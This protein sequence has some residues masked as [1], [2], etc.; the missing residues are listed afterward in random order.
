M[1]ITV[2]GTG[3][4]GLVTGVC[5]S[6]VGNKVICLDIDSDKVKM[7]KNG[8]SPIYEP[9]LSSKIKAGIEFQNLFFTSNSKKAIASS[10]VIFIAVGTPSLDNG[11]TDLSY[12][13][14]AGDSIAEN[15]NNDKIIV[16][17]STVPVGTTHLLKGMVDKYLN[18]NNLTYKVDFISNPE[19]LKE[20]KAIKDF[21]SP[22]RIVLG[23]E[24]EEALKTMKELY[25]PFN[26]H[27]DKIIAMDIKSAELTKYAANAML[28]TKIS[29]INEMANI[30]EK[31][32]ADINNVRNGIGSDSRIG[33][34]FIY[35]GIGFG[36]SCFP[37]D[38]KSI[39]NFSKDVGYNPEIINSVIKV[40]QKQRM[41]F[42]DRIVKFLKSNVDSEKI[43]VG[44]WGLSF[45]PQ[46]DDIREAPSL[47]VIQTL[48]DNDIQVA[49]YDPIAI[50]NVK[51]ELKHKELSFE[52]EMYEVLRSSNALILCTEW[53]DFRSPDFKKMGRLMKN[54]VIFDG[55]NIYNTKVLD[56]FNFKHFQIGVKK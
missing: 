27:H 24:D 32:G 19:F 15:L 10:D 45:K 28:A 18:K 4:V 12:I 16:T 17:K 51:K 3:Y 42:A 9:G 33:F 49:A 13:K 14:S 56:K 50:D 36:G 31:V 38:L 11:E 1:N 47:E 30:C 26:L 23:Y 21:E 7:L 29:F 20:G 54:K 8:K 39:Q 41:R 34:D 6:N 25:R 44:V 52:K 46:T 35:P 37:K 22:D 43:K 48:L 53:I 2:I 40:N 5:L 55:K